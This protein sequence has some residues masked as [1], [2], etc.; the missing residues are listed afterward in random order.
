MNFPIRSISVNKL[1]LPFVGDVAFEASNV[2]GLSNADD[3]SITFYRGD[4]LETI[5]TLK[6]GILI[7]SEEL[8][9]K[10]PVFA[11]KVIAFSDNPKYAFIQLLVDNFSN[12]F[13]SESL[14]SKI[15]SKSVIASSAY[16]ESDVVI[17]DGCQIYP[18]VSIF[19][20]TAIAECCEIQ[21]GSVIGGIGLGDVWYEGRYNKFVH[22]GNV[23]IARNV[24]I[25]CNVTVLKGMLEQTIIGEGTKIGNN[26]NIGHSVR[27]G[28]NC[29]ISSGVTIGGAC[30]IEDNCWI[31]V[32]ATLNDHVHMGRNSKAG[33]GSVIIKDTLED[34]LYLGNPARK[35]SKRLD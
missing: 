14:S 10:V 20:D 16:I 34:S 21:S 35:I 13:E 24:S 9:G 17:E 28:K 32:G 19:K 25:G 23:V 31:A 1:S 5:A 29:Y 2:A 22:L 30:V 3:Q 26:V 12:S 4:D 33:T 11:A 18:N 27:I 7:V 15:V 6:V 8:S